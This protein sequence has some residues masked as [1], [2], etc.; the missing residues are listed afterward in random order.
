MAETHSTRLARLEAR[1]QAILMFIEAFQKERAETRKAI[2]RLT[3]RIEKLEREA[4]T[5]LP[6]VSWPKRERAG[7]S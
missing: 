4:G 5:A 1:N 3:A 2:E 6:I 7:L